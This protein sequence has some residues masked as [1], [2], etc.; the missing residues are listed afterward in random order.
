MLV[1]F[2]QN[3]RLNN[4]GVT[5]SVATGRMHVT[6]DRVWYL[7]SLP[8]NLTLHSLTLE[9]ITA[10]YQPLMW[11]AVM[12]PKTGGSTATEVSEIPL[13][14][15]TWLYDPNSIFKVMASDFLDAGLGQTLQSSGSSLLCSYLTTAQKE[16]PT[17]IP[18]PPKTNCW[19]RTLAAQQQEWEGL[20]TDR[21]GGCDC[22]QA[23]TAR[24][25]I[26]GDPDSSLCQVCQTTHGGPCS[27]LN[28]TC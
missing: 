7:L 22:G 26:M 11:S 19:L 4:Y 16:N 25:L 10:H 13:P 23:N 8:G 24:G 5:L 27:N 15:E 21:R 28:V 2:T 3:D 6:I 20:T 18:A 14:N 12:P 1:F 9:T 17:L